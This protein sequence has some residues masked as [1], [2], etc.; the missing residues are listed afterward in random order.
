VEQQ[1]GQAQDQA[2]QY[3]INSTPSFLIQVGNGKLEKLN[4]QTFALAEF[5]KPIDAALKQAGG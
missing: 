2:Q 3:K 4:Y 5:S 1:L